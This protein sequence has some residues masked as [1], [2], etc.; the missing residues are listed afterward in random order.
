MNTKTVYL[1]LLVFLFSGNVLAYSGSTASKPRKSVCTAPKLTQFT[2]PH[3]SEVTPH[4]GFSFMASKK[5][6]P[7]SIVVNI[8]KQP[9]EIDISETNKGFLITGKI[10]AELEKT[11]ARVQ[12]YAKG[13]NGCKSKDGWLLKIKS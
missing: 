12:I 11:Y 10:P 8:K 4:A 1:G 7:K 5:T 3:L 13:T 9:V 2:P 6:S